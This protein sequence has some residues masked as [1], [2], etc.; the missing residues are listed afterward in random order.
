MFRSFHHATA[1]PSASGAHLTIDPTPFLSTI[2]AVSAALVA[3]IGGLLIAKFVSLDADQRAS[4]KILAGARDRL[5]LAR[6]RA[7]TAWRAILRWDAEGFFANPEII[8]AIVDRGIVSSAELVRMANWSHDAAELTLFITE[9]TEEAALAREAIRS[10]LGRG[11]AFWSDFR[12]RNLDLPQIRWPS[13][14]EHAFDLVARERAAAE[15]VAAKARARAE[16]SKSAIERSLDLMNDT[17]AFGR[18]PALTATFSPPRPQTDY[19]A[20][21]AR[22]ADE[23]R[24]NHARAQQQVE[25]L[26]AELDRLEQEHA[27][28]VRPDGR[29]WAAAVIVVILTVLGVVIP[30]AVMATGPRDL[31]QVRWVLYPFLASLALLIAYIVW[32]LAKLTEGKQDKPT[33]DA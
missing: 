16:S 4:R 33:P 22:R 11:D 23:L 15:A 8:E 3:I 20:I 29:L 1:R 21:A 24:A 30:L 2:A 6:Q 28:I 19:G 18:Q 7:Q 9:V 10:R 12:R 5:D 13:V 32:Y 17:L 26:E 25:D 31:A 27:E 14:W